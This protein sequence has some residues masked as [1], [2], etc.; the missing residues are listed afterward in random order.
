[1]QISQIE[2]QNVVATFTFGP[3]LDLEKI[4]KSFTEECFFETLNDR[5][6]N[7]QVVALRI[8]EPKMSLLIY[9]TGKVVCAGAKTISDAEQS[10]GYLLDRLQKVG[11]NIQV[12][13]DFYT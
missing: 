1:M 7:F 6:F 4:H 8:K 3:E 2:I 9:R 10:A 12:K 5:R 13:N 11:L